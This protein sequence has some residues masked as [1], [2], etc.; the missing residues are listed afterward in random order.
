MDQPFRIKN[1]ILVGIIR[2]AGANQC[3]DQRGLA[4]ITAPGDN[5]RLSL[6]SYHARMNEHAMTSKFADEQAQV[7][8]E[9]LEDVVK[10]RRTCDTRIISVK[11]TETPPIRQRPGAGHHY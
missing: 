1:C 3:C 6:P 10:I 9:S 8:L 5:N 2:R 7:G 11:Q 4:T